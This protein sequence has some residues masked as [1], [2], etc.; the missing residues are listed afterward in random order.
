MIIQVINETDETGFG[1]AKDLLVIYAICMY[2]LYLDVYKNAY[3][4]IYMKMYSNKMDVYS[5]RSNTPNTISP[6]K[7]IL[8]KLRIQLS[9]FFHLYFFIIF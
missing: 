7:I 9:M 8:V 3:K 4:F 6:I 2:Q 1:P 5:I